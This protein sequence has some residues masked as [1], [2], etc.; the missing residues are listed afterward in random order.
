[1]VDLHGA[2]AEG[3]GH[4]HAFP[5]NDGLGLLPAQVPDGRGGVRDSP[6]DIDPFRGRFDSLDL[7][8]LDLENGIGGLAARLREGQ[9]D[10]RQQ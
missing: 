4:L 10:D 8:A 9:Q 5:G 7:S 6:V 2:R 3:V 1:M